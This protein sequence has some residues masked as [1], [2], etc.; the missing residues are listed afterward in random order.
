MASLLLV[1]R[2]AELGVP[3]AHRDVLAVGI[4]CRTN[5][6]RVVGVGSTVGAVS[7]AANALTVEVA[8][9]R[10]LESRGIPLA[11]SLRVVIADDHACG[12]RTE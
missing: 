9:R 10:V 11:L 12:R 6:K 8:N 4:A 7:T 3:A 5:L 1:A 2:A